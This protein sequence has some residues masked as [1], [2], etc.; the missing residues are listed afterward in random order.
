MDF[1]FKLI[2]LDPFDATLCLLKNYASHPTIPF[3]T[4]PRNLKH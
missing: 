3:Y 2:K 1:Q 4:K